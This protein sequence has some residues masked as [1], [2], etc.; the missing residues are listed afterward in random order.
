[1]ALLKKVDKEIAVIDGEFVDLHDTDDKKYQFGDLTKGA[2][3][4]IDTKIQK[5]QAQIKQKKDEKA[6]EKVF[7]KNLQN[8]DHIQ[9]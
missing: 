2:I 5:K 8:I 1:M 3:S 4:K 9:V 7:E 6:I